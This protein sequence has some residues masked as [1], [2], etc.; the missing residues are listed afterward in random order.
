M[1]K[2]RGRTERGRGS[3]GSERGERERDE[4]RREAIQRER[5]DLLLN[6]KYSYVKEYLKLYL[7]IVIKVFMFA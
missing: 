4:R 5:R 1:K 6:P 2:E 3:W 7:C